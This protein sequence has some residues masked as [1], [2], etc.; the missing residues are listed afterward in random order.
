MSFYTVDG[1]ST[2]WLAKTGTAVAANA[3][4][5][6]K[7]KYTSLTAS[8]TIANAPSTDI[9]TNGVTMGTIYN[10]TNAPV[11]YGNLIN[12]YG[13]GSGQIIFGW[14]GADSVTEHI[15]YRSHRDTSTG[16]YGAWKKI[17]FSDDTIPFEKVSS[18]GAA[19]KYAIKTLSAKG[20]SGWTT[21]AAAQGVVPDMAFIAYWNGAYSG[22][23]SNLT[24]CNRGEFGTIVTKSADD[25]LGKTA[26]AASATKLNTAR[27]I[28]TNLASTT[29]AS[30]DGTNNITPGVTGVLAM[31]NGGLGTNN[32]A[33]ARKNL[34]IAPTYMDG[35]PT[36]NTYDGMI[37]IGGG[38]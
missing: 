2:S 22:T 32:A 21:L 15:W 6:S 3:L 28:Q 26:N 36:A 1:D 5:N 23:S 27:T 12:I 31:T 7:G 17:V 11:T 38:A 14:S 35:E 8:G 16:G 25:Y 24:Y 29:Y 9:N 30:F 4:T 37:W 10:T 34:V 18:L 33:V 13:S 19:A 20:D